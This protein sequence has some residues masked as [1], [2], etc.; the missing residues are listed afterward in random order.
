MKEHLSKCKIDFA[1]QKADALDWEGVEWLQSGDGGEKDILTSIFSFELSLWKE[2]ICFLSD[3]N[4]SAILSGN[5]IGSSD[6]LISHHFPKTPSWLDTFH[7]FLHIFALISVVTHSTILFLPLQP[8][9]EDLLIMKKWS[10]TIL[11]YW[12]YLF[13]DSQ[14]YCSLQDYIEIVRSPSDTIY[15]F[16]LFELLQLYLLRNLPQQF[17][18]VREILKERNLLQQYNNLIDELEGA[19]LQRRCQLQCLYEDGSVVRLLGRLVWC[20]R[21]GERT[22][23]HVPILLYCVSSITIGRRRREEERGLLWSL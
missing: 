12:L 13:R 11:F 18:V 7:Y 19:R 21:M 3:G 9:L 23:R 2:I 4:H 14:V 8:F 22:I 17:D 15:S 10:M 16:P 5:C 1:H 6:T 20:L